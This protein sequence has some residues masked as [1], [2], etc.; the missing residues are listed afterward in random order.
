MP[1]RS[2]PPAKSHLVLWIVLGSVAFVGLCVGAFFALKRSGPSL[3]SG[4]G[5]DTASVENTRAWAAAAVERIKAAESS[6]GADAE[7][8]RVE[9][10][11]K[12]AL[13]GKQVRW[14]FP[15]EAVDEGEVKIDTFFG[16][17]VGEHKGPDPGLKGKPLRRVYFRVY[18]KEGVMVGDEVSEADAARLKPGD[19]W[20]VT[21]TVTSIEVRKHDPWFMQSFYTKVVDDLEPFCVDIHVERK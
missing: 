6:G 21:R 18:F 10:Q 16:T 14:T 11:A 20:T 9:K 2:R 19:K 8:A 13:V 3:L 17:R 15:V 5:P 1:P 12:D 4:A 7:I